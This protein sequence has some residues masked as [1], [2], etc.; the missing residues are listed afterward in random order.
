MEAVFFWVIFGIAL[1]VAVAAFGLSW[2]MVV[3]AVV[4]AIY[5]F[6]DD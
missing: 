1:T 3:I 4:L 6:S 2:W 5:W